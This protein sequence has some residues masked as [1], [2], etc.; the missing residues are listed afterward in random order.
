MQILKGP[1]QFVKTSEGKY[2]HVSQKSAPVSLRRDP[3]PVGVDARIFGL[4]SLHPDVDRRSLKA[5]LRK[6][7]DGRPHGAT[8]PQRESR[9]AEREQLRMLQQGGAA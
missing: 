3:A 5:Q 8:A 6:L 7:R 1:V 4:R 2:R 9:N